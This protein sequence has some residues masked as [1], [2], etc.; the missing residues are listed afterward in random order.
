MIVLAIIIY[1][2]GVIINCYLSYRDLIEEYNTNKII[3]IGAFLGYT[4]VCL[5]SWVY[6]IVALTVGLCFWLYTFFNKPLIKKK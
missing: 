4:I 5:T 6:T 3:T 2:I 1:L